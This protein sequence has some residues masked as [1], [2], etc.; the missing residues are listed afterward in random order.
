MPAD[1][2]RAGASASLRAAS[3][4]RTGQLAFRATVVIAQRI[5]EHSDDRP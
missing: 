3:H 1:V 2:V 4:G 5:C